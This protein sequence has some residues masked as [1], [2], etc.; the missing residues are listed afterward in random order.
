MYFDRSV[1]LFV[2]FLPLL[3]TPILLFFG[4]F[5]AENILV[6]ALTLKRMTFSDFES[7]WC[8][9]GVQGILKTASSVRCIKS[10]AV[11][12]FPG[13]Q[14]GTILP[15]RDCPPCPARKISQTPN[16]K[17]FFD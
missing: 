11:I 3:N 9:N 16:N 5:Q 17:S 13:G 15:A 12:G 1:C 10:C 2:C 8:L 4:Q 14:D 6:N 7:F